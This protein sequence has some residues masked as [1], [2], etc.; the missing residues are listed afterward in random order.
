M[1]ITDLRLAFKIDTG[2]DP[3]W[4]KTRDGKDTYDTSWQR[5]WPRTIYGEWLEE[6]LIKGKYL[7]DRFYK[8]S[9][10]MPAS[11]YF[12]DHRRKKEVIFADYIE[13]L[14]TFLLKFYPQIVTNIIKV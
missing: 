9:G 4:G 14:E 11:T 6:K 8:V 3:L 12:G 10:E 2:Q 1:T 13:W 7:R 5:G